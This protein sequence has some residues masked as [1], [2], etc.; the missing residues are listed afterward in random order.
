MENTY[1]FV[2]LCL[3][4]LALFKA[5]DGIRKRWEDNRANRL[6]IAWH[7]LGFMLMTL[8]S[9]YA[10][11]SMFGWSLVEWKAIM[12]LCVISYW[13]ADM[14]YNKAIGQQLFYA[15]DGK[16]SVTEIVLSWIGSKVGMN[17][18][19]ITLMAKLIL[20]VSAALISTYL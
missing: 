8:V 4:V 17:L 14:I 15:G 13:Q 10:Y 11:V 2:I 6:S 12:W 20:T 9:V 7:I 18:V 5:Y 1:V 3:A 19:S 16:G